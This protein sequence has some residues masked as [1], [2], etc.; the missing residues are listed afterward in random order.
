[1]STFGFSSDFGFTCGDYDEA[2]LKKAVVKRARKIILAMDSSKIDKSFQYTFAKMDDIDIV[3]L[4]KRPN[5]GFIEI[6]EHSGVK[7]VY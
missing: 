7:L 1:M 2:Q 4:D 5:D 6:C 3:V